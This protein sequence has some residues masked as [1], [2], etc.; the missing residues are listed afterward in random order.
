MNPAALN[1]V[2]CDAA[3]INPLLHRL[4]N[5]PVLRK[6]VLKDCLQLDPR[7]IPKAQ[8]RIGLFDLISIIGNAT[9]YL[10]PDW[11]YRS[12]EFWATVLDSIFYSAV[13]SAP[14]IG[15]G[16]NLVSEY[17]FLWCP[18]IFYEIYDGP[19]YKT[20]I[21]D[22]IIPAD[23]SPIMIGGLKTIAEMALIAPYLILEETLNG[24]WSNSRILLATSPKRSELSEFFKAEIVWDAPRFGLQI[25][26]SLQKRKNNQAD[27]V[28]F[29]KASLLIQNLVY[30][31]DIDRSLEEMVSAYIN[32]TQFHRPTI[33]EVAKSL[34]MSTRTLNRRLEQSGV[35]FRS[36]LEQSLKSRTQLLL[37]QGQLSRGEIAERLG[38]KDQASFSRA[39]R[40]WQDD[41]T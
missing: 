32:A 40:R 3:L 39:L 8:A 1:L 23:L 31:P 27:P 4:V 28:K 12:P 30:P 22:V 20:F 33:V 7:K 35:S 19:D 10:G 34:G 6:E 13:R 16:L 24:Q 29:R 18:A 41:Q 26:T 2:T 17:G 36:L 9:A 25:P 38:Y 5:E 37:A 15:D 14:D 11:P 21:S